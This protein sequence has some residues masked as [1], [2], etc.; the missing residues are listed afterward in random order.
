MTRPC[1]E[2]TEQALGRFVENLSNRQFDA[3]IELGW[4][5]V[6]GVADDEAMVLMFVQCGCSRA[7]AEAKVV[8]VKAKPPGRRWWLER[9]N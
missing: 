5:M 9:L 3:W 8:K 1:L 4:K 7:E 6:D 2:V